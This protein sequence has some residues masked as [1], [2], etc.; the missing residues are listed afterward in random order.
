MQFLQRSLVAGTHK[1]DNRHGQ[2]IPKEFLKQFESNINFVS[3]LI[4][5]GYSFGDLHI[6]QVLR[7]WLERS[8]DRRLEVVSPGASI[9]PFLLHLSPQVSVFKEAASD[10][11]DR[12]TGIVRSR[13]ELSQRRL[14]AWF[15]RHR[16]APDV[17]Q[18]FCTFMQE[19]QNASF[20]IL[21]EKMKHRSSRKEE[22]ASPERAKA[23][24]EFARELAEQNLL[25]FDTLVEE[26]LEKEASVS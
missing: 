23:P 12:L 10:Y 13:R 3:T 18:K 15:Y 16:N 8:P 4:C 24:E 9:P 6:N 21:L 11:L 5:I 20:R 19:R 1:F 25:S 7:D 14:G 2:V 17:Q 26:F 22:G